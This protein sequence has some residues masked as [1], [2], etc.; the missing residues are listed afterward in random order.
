MAD[1][2]HWRRL[3]GLAVFAGLIAW[4][5]SM[6]SPGSAPVD[7]RLTDSGD[8]VRDAVVRAFER[9]VFAL[10]DRQPAF[11]QTVHLEFDASGGAVPAGFRRLV[12]EIS[13]ATQ[14]RVSPAGEAV[15]EIVLII[16]RSGDGAACQ[17]RREVRMGGIVRGAIAVDPSQGIEAAQGCLTEKLLAMLGMPR[18]D[19]AAQP[20]LSSR[21]RVLLRLAYSAELS[22]GMGRGAMLS[23]VRRQ[24]EAMPLE[25]LCVKPDGFC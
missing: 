2:F 14:G 9:R 10:A 3:I 12:D 6:L 24:V 23:A 17:I 4:A 19:M 22:P 8:A 11:G 25:S 18:A 1:V 5:A 13:V 20:G 15:G 7:P 16:D 21:E